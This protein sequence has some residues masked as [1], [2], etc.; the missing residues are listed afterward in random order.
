MYLQINTGGEELTLFEIMVAKTYDLPRNFDLSVEY[1]KVKDNN[2]GSE[3]DL[4]DA[5]YETVPPVTI[6][7]SIAANLSANSKTRCT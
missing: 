5:G 7:Q 4:E 1:E 3:K 6:L 2:N